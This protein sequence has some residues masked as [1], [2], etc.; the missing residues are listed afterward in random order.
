M[1]VR[2]ITIRWVPETITASTIDCASSMVGARLVIVTGKY[3][4]RTSRAAVSPVFH[5]YCLLSCV[6][7]RSEYNL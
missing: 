5:F 7:M 1:L 6:G 4:I 2:D 3:P